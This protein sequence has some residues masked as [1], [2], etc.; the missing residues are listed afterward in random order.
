MTMVKPTF[1]A[2]SRAFSASASISVK[3]ARSSGSFLSRA[4]GVNVSRVDYDTAVAAI[5]NAAKRGLSFGATAL[6]V[7][8]VVRH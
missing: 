3:M 2:S 5:I 8:G 1:F 4:L 6:A 7:H